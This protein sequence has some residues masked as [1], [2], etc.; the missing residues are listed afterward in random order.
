MTGHMTPELLMLTLSVVLG[1]VHISASAI[2][3]TA[4]YGSKWNIG[5]RD[6]EMPPLNALAGR[7]QRA[8]QNFLETFPLFAALVLIADAANRHGPLTVWGSELYFVC[9]VIYLPLY[10]AGIPVARTVVWSAALLGI[11]MILRALF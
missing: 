1:F 6:A 3:R 11:L 8:S 9:R 4:Q 5:A 10:A 2:A 7:L